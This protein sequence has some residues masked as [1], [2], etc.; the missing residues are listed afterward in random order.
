MQSQARALA[1]APAAC[2]H[3]ASRCSRV[4]RRAHPRNGSV[5][6]LGADF[7]AA[8]AP[9]VAG[10]VAVAPDGPSQRVIPG[11]RRVGCVLRVVHALYVDAADVVVAG[12]FRKAVVRLVASRAISRAR[13]P[14]RA[15]AARSPAWP[16]HGRH[17]RQAVL[18]R[19]RVAPK[20]HTR[21]ARTRGCAT[22]EQQRSARNSCA[23]GSAAR[24]AAPRQHGCS[25][26]LGAGALR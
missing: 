21:N 22:R 7:D 1:T 3:S 5:E 10:R 15:A 17:G 12:V 23:S 11:H 6:L 13:R 2:S 18:R 24:A 25:C 26:G 4:S 9:A 20:R 16:R 8:H 14:Q 19:P